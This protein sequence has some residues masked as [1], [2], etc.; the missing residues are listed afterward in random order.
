MRSEFDFIHHIKKS[1]GL[2]RIGDDCAVLPK[3]SKTD[4]LITAD[5]LVEDVDFRIGW[6]T[7]E[8]LGHKA[9]AVSLSDIAAMGGQPTFAM[10]SLGVPERLWKSDFLDRFYAGWHGLAR[11]F[12]V[13]LVGGDVSRVPEKFVIDS[14]VL[15][16]VERGRAIP[17][18]G[19]KPGDKIYVTGSLGGAAGGLKLL[20]SGT[21]P[22]QDLRQTVREMIE[23]QLCPA[24]RLGVSSQLPASAMIDLSDGLSSDLGHICEASGA[25]AVIFAEQ[26]PIDIRLDSIF[27]SL[28]EK[29]HLALDGG[30]DFE[31][32]FTAD[33]KKNLPAEF[34][35][36]TCI[37]EITA[38]VGRMELIRDGVASEM[39][40][41]GFQHFRSN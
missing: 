22:D 37:G 9:L 36:L 31:L 24:P 1:Y 32:L 25:G 8:F 16:E 33:P 6:T 26:I 30:E 28:D 7:P 39:K 19:A 15:G 10:L 23:R 20:E 40:P 38:N 3:D 41:K 34:A 21:R 2:G 17:R 13:E 29:L 35:D 5:M 14:I 12:G 4:L 11:D 27:T 18:S